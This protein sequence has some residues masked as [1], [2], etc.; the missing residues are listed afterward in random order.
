MIKESPSRRLTLIDLREALLN[1]I[2][3]PFQKERVNNQEF[4]P[5]FLS[6]KS[7]TISRKCQ[8]HVYVIFSFLLIFLIL[9]LTEMSEAKFICYKCLVCVVF[10]YNCFTILINYRFIRQPVGAVKSIAIV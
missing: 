2:K 9:L 5:N 8:S 1:T 7:E 3:N 4:A 10:N 6:N